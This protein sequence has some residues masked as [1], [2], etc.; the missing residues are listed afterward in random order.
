M[1]FL[2]SFKTATFALKVNKMRSFL[3]MLG[4][5]IG[6]SAVILMVSL[7][8]GI[9]NVILSQIESIGHNLAFILP[10]GMKQEKGMPQFSLST[11]TIK[12]L[13]LS[14]V[15][16]LKEGFYIK[17]AAP[18]VFGPAILEY[19]GEQKKRDFIGTFPNF[20][21]IRGNEIL[22]GRFFTQKE[23]DSMQR[24]VVLG[25]KVKE[26]LFGKEKAVGKT[27]KI[28]RR[29]F[30]IIGVIEIKGMKDPMFDPNDLVFIPLSVAQKQMLGI[31]YLNVIIMK[32]ESAET[33]DIAVEEAKLI[34]RKRHKIKDP[35]KDDFTILS[36]EYIAST[37]NLIGGIFTIF[38]SCI[39]GISL[40]VGGIGVMNIML[41]SVTERTREI[42]LRKAVGARKKDILVQFLLESIILTLLGGVIGIFLGSLG[43]YL[44]G[45]AIGKALGVEW[46]FS[47]SLMAIILGFGVSTLV[48]LIFGIYPAKKAADSLPIEALRYE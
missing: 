12:T 11:M 19:K 6:V 45:I 27:I 48:G 23:E 44:G 8:E 15:E 29:R 4:I 18:W 13:K 46:K 40:I 39:A 10:G 2:D 34:L 36:Q 47:L 43:S 9:Q 25:K 5:I 16:A 21:K 28:N 30:R 20:Q 7:G 31:D 17:D 38:L 1:K 42:G 37:F 24:V 41:V 32:A 35:S 26:K 33:L 14:D 3:A 22:E